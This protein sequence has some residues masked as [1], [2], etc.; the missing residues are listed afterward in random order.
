MIGIVTVQPGDD[1]T[2]PQRLTVLLCIILGQVGSYSRAGYIPPPLLRLVQSAGYMPP[3]LLRLV[4]SAGYQIAISAVFFGIEPGNMSMKI[5]IGVI[6]AVLLAPS[7]FAFK[8]MFKKSTYRKAPS[9]RGDPS[10]LAARE[11][12]RKVYPCIP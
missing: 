2:R 1:F 9:K 8:M 6:T 5:V 11:R 7:K 3:P 4:L 10:R 12:K